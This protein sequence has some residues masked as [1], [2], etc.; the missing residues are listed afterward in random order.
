MLEAGTITNSSSPYASPV[1]L[2]KKKDN[3]WRLCVDYRNLNSM[4]IKDRFP[5][6]LIEDL[7]DELGGSSVYSK[8][9]LRA[10][11]HQ[12]RMDQADTHKTAFKTH[13]GRYEY[14]VMPFG[15]T[16]A[17]ATFQSLMNSVFKPFL[18]NFVLIFFDDI[19]IYS[20]S[21][22]EHK[23]HLQQVFE[24][25]R[26]NKLYAKQSKCDFVT[27]HVE[28]LGHYIEAAGV[29]T[30]PSKIK[31]IVEWPK[32][33]ALKQ[34]RGFLRLAGYYRRF[35]KIF[36]RIARPLT[37]LTKK[38]A[39]DWNDEAQEAFVELKS[40]LCQAPVLALPDFTKQFVVE[41]D[42]CGSGIGAV[43]M[44]EGHPIAYISRHLKG[45]QLHLSIYEKELLAVVFAVQKW[46]HCI[47][48]DHFII[49]TDQR[50]LKYLLEQRLN[51]PIQQQWLPKLMEFDYEIQYRQGTDN[52]AADAL[53]RVEGSHGH[54]CSRL[55]LDETNSGR[56]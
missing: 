29:S 35:F 48:H 56:L 3:T 10:V 12:V 52:L 55:R 34:L 18:R 53:S 7:M 45:K 49:R 44:Q 43:L 14:M 31:A 32:P 38:D 22:E 50:S 2:V 4:T 8:I 25:M 46:R 5:I 24:V 15:L 30:D 23:H 1:V 21:V 6:P 33:K 39:F 16:N 17:P 13:S 9:D 19:L 28:Y 27:T 51:T 20:K 54:F 42:A 36:G 41:L 47:F 26:A 11:Y 37:M 40:A